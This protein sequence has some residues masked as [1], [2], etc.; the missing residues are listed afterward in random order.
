MTTNGNVLHKKILFWVVVLIILLYEIVG[1][2]FNQETYVPQNLFPDLIVEEGCEMAQVVGK[3]LNPGILFGDG[4][5]TFRGKSVSIFTIRTK[6][7]IYDYTLSDY[8]EYLYP[9]TQ[10]RDWI[11]ICG[12]KEDGQ[13]I[14]SVSMV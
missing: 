8:M 9:I 5:L 10:S 4:V 7:G 12:E 13:F 6:Q 1:S 3:Y 2:R 11:K 14:F